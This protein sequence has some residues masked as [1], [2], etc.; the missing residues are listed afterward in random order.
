[1]PAVELKQLFDECFVDADT[2]KLFAKL[3]KDILNE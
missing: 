1:M 3:E 2:A